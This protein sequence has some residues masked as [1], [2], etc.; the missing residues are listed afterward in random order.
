[1]SAQVL[2]QKDVNAPLADQQ[3]LADGGKDVKS[4]EYHRK[5]FQSKIQEPYDDVRCLP[6]S[7]FALT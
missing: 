6:A 7:M 3:V 5:V 4:M 2:G 1:M